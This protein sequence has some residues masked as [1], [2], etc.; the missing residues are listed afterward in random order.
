MGAGR[1]RRTARSG[2]L[3]KHHAHR[4]LPVVRAPN[5]FGHKALGRNPRVPLFACTW[6]NETGSETKLRHLRHYLAR[7]LESWRLERIYNAESGMR[8]DNKLMYKVQGSMCEVQSQ[9]RRAE[10]YLK[11]EMQRSRFE[12]GGS[13]Q[14]ENRRNLRNLRIR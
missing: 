5:R 8:N 4:V 6:P 9:Y 11:C 12:V 7:M 3:G 13:C 10:S 14:V 1:P 2:S